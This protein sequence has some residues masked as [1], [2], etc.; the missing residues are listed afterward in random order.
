[1][2]EEVVQ[3]SKL[4][5]R[6]GEYLRTFE[7]H[8]EYTKQSLTSYAECEPCSS[9]HVM[10]SVVRR[11]SC[12]PD[13]L[14]THY[15][16]SVSSFGHGTLRTSR[17]RRNLVDKESDTF[18]R[19]PSVEQLHTLGYIGNTKEGLALHEYSRYPTFNPLRVRK[20]PR[21]QLSPF[22]FVLSSPCCID[23]MPAASPHRDSGRP[24]TWRN[25]P[26]GLWFLC[27]REAYDKPAAC[28][29]NLLRF[30]TAVAI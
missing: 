9:N 5:W 25:L 29:Q 20:W 11:S 17:R 21:I 7:D 3:G 10:Q 26:L 1:M 2:Q 8:G 16:C 18:D 27:L 14:R 6:S 4:L 30:P 19:I 28:S 13:L 15:F 22:S 12:R 23:L 24:P